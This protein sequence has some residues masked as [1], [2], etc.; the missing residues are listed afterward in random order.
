MKILIID[1]DRWFADVV[2]KTLHGLGWKTFIARDGAKGID[3][4]DSFDP[5]AVLLD[6][7]LPGSTAPALLNELQSHTDLADLPVVLC[8]SVNS[9]EFD[10][11]SLKSYGV[12]SVLDKAYSEPGDIVKALIHAVDQN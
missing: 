7:M 3:A 4:I 5:D 6:V 11:D 10:A 8:T 1:D 2:A 12:K 9:S